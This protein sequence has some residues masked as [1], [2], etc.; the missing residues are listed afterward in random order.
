MEALT[1]REEEEALTSAVFKRLDLLEG[2]S[3]QRRHT[4]KPAETASDHT[5]LPLKSRITT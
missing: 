3:K 4:Y 1:P 2:H 5:I